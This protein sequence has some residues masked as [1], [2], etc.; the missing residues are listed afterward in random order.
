MYFFFSFQVALSYLVFT[1]LLFG[2]VTS[3]LLRSD[4]R[5]LGDSWYIVLLLV[6]IPKV[7]IL[8]QFVLASAEPKDV[9]QIVS[10]GMY[11][12]APSLLIDTFGKIL[13]F[14]VFHL[15]NVP[16]L[17]MVAWYAFVFN[18]LD[19]LIFISLYPATL[20]LAIELMH[21]DGKSPN[22]WDPK[23][24]MAKLKRLVDNEDRSPVVHR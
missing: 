12:L 16:Q 8:A 1:F 18:L 14:R 17:V 7:T 15:T 22:R 3:S 19:L 5:V 21:C 4:Y 10:K 24:M 11:V 6:D 2:F 9:S 20:A 13:L 23:A